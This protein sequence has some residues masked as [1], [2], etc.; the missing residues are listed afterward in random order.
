MSY[1]LEDLVKDDDVQVTIRKGGLESHDDAK[2]RRLQEGVIIIFGLLT[3]VSLFSICI[4]LIVAKNNEP[5]FNTAV[6]ISSGFAGY[7]LRAKPH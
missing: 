3:L 2:L 7:L 5:A 6:A 1:S 4:Y